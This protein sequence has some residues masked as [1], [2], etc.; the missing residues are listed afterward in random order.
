MKI[1]KFLQIL[2]YSITNGEGIKLNINDK[3]LTIELHEGYDV[4][5]VV[6]KDAQNGIII[7]IVHEVDCGMEDFW[8]PWVDQNIEIYRME[9]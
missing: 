1:K 5:C 7:A 8:S 4:P 9:F 3:E 2:A 6:F